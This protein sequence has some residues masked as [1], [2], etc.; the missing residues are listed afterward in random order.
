MLASSLRELEEA[1][2]V[3][4]KQYMEMPLRVEYSLTDRCGSLIPILAQ[5][6]QWGLAVQKKT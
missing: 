3:V 5:L 1:G 6:A 2:L 4:R